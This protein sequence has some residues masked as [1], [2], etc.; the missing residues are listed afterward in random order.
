MLTTT[1]MIRS[2][3]VY[4]NLM[5][6]LTASNTKLRRRARRIVCTVTGVD[7]AQ[8]ERLLEQTGYRAKPAILMALANCSAAEAHRRL[9]AAGGFLRLALEQPSSSSLS[10]RA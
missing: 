5:V 9:E 4:G 10:G 3:K 7:E 2:G 6:D 1:A 8:A